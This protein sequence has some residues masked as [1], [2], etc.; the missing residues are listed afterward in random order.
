MKT[1]NKTIK[2][3]FLC[4]PTF[5]TDEQNL[6]LVCFFSIVLYFTIMI[7]WRSTSKNISTDDNEF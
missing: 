2:L 6:F 4:I 1:I 3:D 5:R 7:W